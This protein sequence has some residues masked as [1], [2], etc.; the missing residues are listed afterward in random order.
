MGV[1]L[2]KA[3]CREYGVPRLTLPIRRD[4]VVKVI[5]GKFKDETPAK[6]TRVRRKKYCLFIDNIQREK[7]NGVDPRIRDFE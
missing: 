1:A 5:T 6:V 2:S 4:D 7:A 3:L